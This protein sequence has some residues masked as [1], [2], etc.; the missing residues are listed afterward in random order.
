MFLFRLTGCP[1]NPC[2]AESMGDRGYHAHKMS[3]TSNSQKK[4]GGRGY[5]IFLEH[6]RRWSSSVQAHVSWGYA[7]SL[8]SWTTCRSCWTSPGRNRRACWRRRMERSIHP[9]CFQCWNVITWL[10]YR[11][12]NIRIIGTILRIRLLVFMNKFREQF[13]AD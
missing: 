12:E 2:I 3:L 8:L 11:I 13:L 6:L 10:L 9:L 7:S 1:A 5:R 4:K